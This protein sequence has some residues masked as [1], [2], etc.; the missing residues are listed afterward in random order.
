VTGTKWDE[1]QKK[2]E[3][4]IDLS[5]MRLEQMGGNLFG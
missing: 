5:N 2:C 3:S 4:D 1:E